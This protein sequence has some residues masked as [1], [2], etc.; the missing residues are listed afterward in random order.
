MGLCLEMTRKLSQEA[1]DA[2]KALTIE[3]KVMC[4]MYEEELIGEANLDEESKK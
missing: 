3:K 4:A 2:E 1:K